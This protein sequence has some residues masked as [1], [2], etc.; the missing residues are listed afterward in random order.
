MAVSE[1]E[2]RFLD[3][4][5]RLSNIAKLPEGLARDDW[6]DLTDE[7]LDNADLERRETNGEYDPTILEGGR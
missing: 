3:R 1:M 7:E 2:Q 5:R 4:V 6:D